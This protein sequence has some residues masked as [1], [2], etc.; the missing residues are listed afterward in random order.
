M[1]RIGVVVAALASVLA[2]NDNATTLPALLLQDQ[3]GRPLNLADLRGRV[4]VIV[5]GTRAGVDDHIAW[6]RRLDRGLAA[7]GAYDPEGEPA[8]R[9]VR[10]LAVAQMG[11]IP[12]GFRTIVRTAVRPHVPSDF[13]LWLDWDDRMSALFGASGTQSSVV[14]ADRAGHVRL[15][16]TEPPTEPAVAR[17]L[18]V[19]RSLL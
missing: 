6:G 18:D 15:V 4:V 5:Y 9:P 2:V 1:V 16:T 12:A 13:S 7:H 8:R 19:V 10:I 3:A 17:V 11:G 14:V